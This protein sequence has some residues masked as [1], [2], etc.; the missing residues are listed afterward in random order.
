MQTFC[1]YA[2]CHAQFVRSICTKRNPIIVSCKI[3]NH[4]AIFANKRKW[5]HHRTLRLLSLPG[6]AA[7]A[8]S[9]LTHI[10]PTRSTSFRLG[11]ASYKALTSL[12]R[13]DFIY[14]EVKFF[15]FL[16]FWKNFEFSG[17]KWVFSKKWPWVLPFWASKKTPG[18]SGTLSNLH[19]LKDLWT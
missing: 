15:V 4:C 11:R 17:K 9:R 13:E 3:V 10:S 16:S 5:K 6:N 8:S 14:Y 12:G 18:L 19:K 2:C 1:E 7:S